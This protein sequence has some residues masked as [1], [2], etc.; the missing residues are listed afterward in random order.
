MEGI[1]ELSLLVRQTNALLFNQKHTYM[2][3]KYI[4]E[5][6]R[7]LATPVFSL[8]HFFATPLRQPP[9]PTFRQLPP[10]AIPLT[11]FICIIIRKRERDREIACSALLLAF[12]ARILSYRVM[13]QAYGPSQAPWQ[14]YLS[15]SLSFS[16]S[17]S[18]CTT[19]TPT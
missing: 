10:F 13:F 6:Q 12:R 19:I 2:Y 17:L 18:M 16:L 5:G 14:G 8:D 7:S 11:S 4:W 15:L 3:I 1:N 9:A